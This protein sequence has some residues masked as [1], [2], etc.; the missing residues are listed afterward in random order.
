MEI[1]HIHNYWP[2]WQKEKILIPLCTGKM[3]HPTL[4]LHFDF[5]DTVLMMKKRG[6]QNNN[7]LFWKNYSPSIPTM[8]GLFGNVSNH[9]LTA[10]MQIHYTAPKIKRSISFSVN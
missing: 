6:K 1:I 5:F 2:L 3:S 8:T 10:F 4:G 7:G 9:T